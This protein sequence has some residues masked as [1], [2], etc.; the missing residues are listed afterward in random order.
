MLDTNICIRVLRDRP[1]SA[2]EQFNAAAGSICISA[3]TL[4]ELF[5][6]AAK[7]ARPDHQRSEVE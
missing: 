7:S 1:P 6:G 5:H 3:V 4:A 2:R